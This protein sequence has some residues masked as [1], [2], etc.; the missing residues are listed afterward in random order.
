MAFL[1]SGYSCKF[2]LYVQQPLTGCKIFGG[3][4]LRE[5]LPPT[6]GLHWSPSSR[7]PALL[8]NRWALGLKKWLTSRNGTH[9]NNFLLKWVISTLAYLLL[10]F[11][12]P[13]NAKPLA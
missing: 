3:G 12:V 13:R 9:D 7:E 6:F 5:S 8:F 11:L 2:E 10:T 1:N 4:L